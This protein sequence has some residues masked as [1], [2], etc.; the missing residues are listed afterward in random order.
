M[1]DLIH[2]W[3]Q[4]G[5]GQ[6]PLI[7]LNM[8]ISCWGSVMELRVVLAK[9][10]DIK[11][12]KS[13]RLHKILNYQNTSNFSILQLQAYFNTL[14]TSYQHNILTKILQW[15]KSEL[16]DENFWSCFFNVKVARN[17]RQGWRNIHTE[18]K[19]RTALAQSE[20]FEHQI[21][22]LYALYL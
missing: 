3:C 7:Y 4:L 1:Q 14:K 9:V 21:H 2:R 5:N 11:L 22:I 10:K 15:I 16:F 19:L 13:I 6:Y 17:H 12:Q 20:D 8:L 18:R